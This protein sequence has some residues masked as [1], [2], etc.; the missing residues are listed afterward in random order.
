MQ[1]NMNVSYS[2]S[3]NC[4]YRENFTLISELP[5]DIYLPED[6]T[7]EGERIIEI[8]EAILDVCNSWDKIEKYDFF[9]IITLGENGCKNEYPVC[10]EKDG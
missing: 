9:Y 3:K 5:R 4:L 1:I 10:V 8:K 2:E 7:Y 6:Y